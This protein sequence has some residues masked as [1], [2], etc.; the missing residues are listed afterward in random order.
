MGDSRHMGSLLA[1]CLPTD[2]MPRST[3]FLLLLAACYAADA[4][5]ADADRDVY[6][7]LDATSASVVG[8]TRPFVVE[9]AVDTLRKQLQ[10]SGP[11]TEP[12]TL[13]LVEALDIAAENS[14]EFQTRKEQ[15][16]LAA[17]NLTR[18]Q[19]DFAWRFGGGSTNAIGGQADDTADARL[20][21]DLSAQAN[22]IY[23]TR[24]V[25]SFVQT[26][27]RSVLS[28]GSFDGSSILDLTITQPLLRGS[29]RRIARE[30]LTQ[31]ER[32]VVYAMRDYERF[33]VQFAIDLVADYWTITRQMNDLINVQ[34]N[35]E[36][37]QNTS[38]E[39][40]ELFNAGRKNIIDLGRSE[41]GEYTADAQ[42]V[43]ARNRLQTSLDQFKLTLGLPVEA[44]IQLDAAEL[45]KLQARG[46][47]PVTIPEARAIELSLQRR[48][49][50]RTTVDEVEDAG[51]KALIAED[52]LGM[53]LDF[54]A[55]LSVP[56]EAGKGLDFDWSRVNWSAGFDLDLVLNRVPVRNAYRSALITFDQAVRAREQNEDQLTATVRRALR[57]IDAALQTYRIQS[58]AVTLGE[59]RVEATTELYEAGR[60]PAFEKLT[61]QSDLL[62]SQLA[63]SAAIVDYAIARLDLM[64]TLEAIRLEPVGLRFDLE[65]PMPDGK[66]AE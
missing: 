5:K 33:R 7:I 28:G 39:T 20:G 9:R 65:L 42:R 29:G 8:K 21:D 19:N 64:N 51:R 37:V 40:R 27:L 55:A 26:F 35:Y 47:E 3:P 32:D 16:Y 61:A 34:A 43:A 25:A 14:R 62:S 31:A 17:L 49:D 15:L 58:N 60:E 10:R 53:Q 48:Y 12:R 50:F 1:D 59:Q 23:G 38:Q 52:A 41:Q 4:N 30:P 46:A 2:G 54:T 45:T 11:G 24:V 44:W 22:S 56:P 63:R 6:R 66:S 13:T 57:D 18:N 36:Q